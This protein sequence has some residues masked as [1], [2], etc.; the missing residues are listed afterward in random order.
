MYYVWCVA[1]NRP[2]VLGCVI[3]EVNIVLGHFECHSRQRDLSSVKRL[4]CFCLVIQGITSLS[5]G[6]RL[7]AEFRSLFPRKPNSEFWS[8]A[9][10]NQNAGQPADCRGGYGQTGWWVENVS[11]RNHPR[12]LVHGRWRAT[13]ANPSRP[14]LEKS[15]NVEVERGFSES[16]KSVTDARIRPS[17]ASIRNSCD[18]WWAEGF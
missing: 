4:L 7:L 12:G 8:I 10:G 15:W 6:N 5:W 18:H 11:P 9:K 3:S 13:E 14:L 16:D 1:G 2:F 17:E